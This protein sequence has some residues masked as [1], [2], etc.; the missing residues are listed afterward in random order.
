L[1]EEAEAAECSSRKVPIVGIGRLFEEIAHRTLV[2]KALPFGNRFELIQLNNIE[3]LE[4]ARN[5]FEFLG[6]Q[7]AQLCVIAAAPRVQCEECLH[8]NLGG[9][10]LG[11]HFVEFLEEGLRLAL[12][13]RR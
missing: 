8:E 2:A 4:L 13:R 1:D 6:G 5:C 3:C 10:A 7:F 12:T 9:G 11:E